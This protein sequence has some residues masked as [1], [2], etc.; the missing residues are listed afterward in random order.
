MS[1]TNLS[2]DS[3]KDFSKNDQKEILHNYELIRLMV[4]K[5][6]SEHRFKHSVSVA[7]V[8]KD[9]AIAHNY[10]VE[11]AYLAGLLHDC[12]K[13]PDS[14][15]SGVLEAYLQKYEPSKLN[16]V[17]GAYHSWVAPYYLKEKLDFDDDEILNA[18]YNH[19]ILNSYDTL[20]L[21]LY[22]ADKREPLRGI[23]DN[24]LDLAKKDLENAYEILVKEVEDYIK[25]KK[26]ERFIKNCL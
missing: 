26:N 3:F 5:N 24:I 25:N 9:L 15:T 21:I 6:V 7:E 19:T 17:Y 14:D 16:N 10:N 23:N 18:I 13:F 2:F 8:C 4:K 1:F 12:C 22:I 20:S 11:K